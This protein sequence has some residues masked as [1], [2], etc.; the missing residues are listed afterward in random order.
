MNAEEPNI[1]LPVSSN[2]EHFARS[3]S[4]YADDSLHARWGGQESSAV[5]CALDSGLE[6]RVCGTNDGKTSTSAL[7]VLLCMTVFLAW[8]AV[9]KRRNAKQR[10][11]LPA[12][13][14]AGNRIEA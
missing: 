4:I 6:C 13:Q 12:D 2:I 1:Q 7:G 9:G 3:I 11:G 14:V 8:T 5:I 10:S